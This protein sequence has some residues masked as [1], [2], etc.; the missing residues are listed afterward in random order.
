MYFCRIF[1]FC[2]WTISAGCSFE[3]SSRVGVV[4]KLCKLLELFPLLES[5]QLLLLCLPLADVPSAFVCL[6]CLYLCAG[7]H[8]RPTWIPDVGPRVLWEDTVR[9]RWISENAPTPAAAGEKYV[10]GLLQKSTD[11]CCCQ[12]SSYCLRVDKLFCTEYTR[13]RPSE[14]PSWLMQGYVFSPA[15]FCLFVLYPVSLHWTW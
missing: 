14:H 7:W 4:E 8:A 1:S 3:L 11:C 10:P 5:K 12:S 9:R 2:E 15:V 13:E 6:L